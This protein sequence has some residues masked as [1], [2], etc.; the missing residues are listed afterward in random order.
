MNFMV[1][2]IERGMCYGA[3]PVYNLTVTGDGLVVYEGIKNVKNTGLHLY[4][5]SRE[6]LMT[7]ANEFVAAGFFDMNSS[8]QTMSATD[9]PSVNIS[10]LSPYRSKE[11]DHY[12]GDF[13]AP[14]KLK[15]LEDRF[16]EIVNID[17]LAELGDKIGHE[18]GPWGQFL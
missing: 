9:M 10:Y 13:S 5:L 17:G 4:E 11:I 2:R 6:K 15:V 12:H 18:R 14:K 1:M 7:L 8:Y 3:C 16:D